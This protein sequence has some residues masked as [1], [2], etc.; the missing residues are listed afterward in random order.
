MP[1]VLGRDDT[2][3]VQW[4][5]SS[6]GELVLL[7]VLVCSDELQKFHY[8]Q[9]TELFFILH[10]ARLH[11]IAYRKGKELLDWKLFFGGAVAFV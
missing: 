1:V 6:I 10:R 7:A 8:K 4:R 2:V 5:S 9:G 11:M 3:A